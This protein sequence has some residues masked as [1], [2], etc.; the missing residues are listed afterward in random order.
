MRLKFVLALV[1]LSAVLAACAAPAAG[2]PAATAP[3]PPAASPSTSTHTAEPSPTVTVQAVYI[4]AIYYREVAP[5][6]FHYWHFYPD[7][8]VTQI[9][10]IMNPPQDV[11][12]TYQFNRKYLEAGRP[13][14]NIT[15]EY[16][17]LNGQI[18]ITYPPVAPPIFA[19]SGTYQQEK[20]M[21]SMPDGTT[22]EY[23]L[24][25]GTP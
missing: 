19:T 1:S 14:E 21:M 9:E 13:Q 12:G 10:A 16:V 20:I 5:N 6:R 17:I 3:Q 4:D 8:Q 2:S 22:A 25:D 23:V 11:Y 24:Y 7:G 15:G 18:T